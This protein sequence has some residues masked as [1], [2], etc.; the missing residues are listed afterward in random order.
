MISGQ[1][2]ISTNSSVDFN[3]AATMRAFPVEVVTFQQPS[4]CAVWVTVEDLT[5]RAEEVIGA[6][7]VKGH[8]IAV[9]FSAGK[10]SSV[11]LNLVL[12]VAKG[13]VSKGVALPPIVVAHSDTM[14][15][16]PE[17]TAY[18]AKEMASVR[19]FASK[20]RLNVAVEIARP[21][22]TNQWPVRVI[23]GR[24]LPTFASSANRDCTISLK[25]QPQKKLRKQLLKRLAADGSGALE[26]ITLLGTRFEESTSREGRMRER[27]ESGQEVRRG[28]DENGK[29]AGLFLSPIADW[30]SDDVWEYLGSAR[31][32]DIDSYS[33]F[34]ETFR[35]YTAGM[36]TSCVIV[37][38]D[39]HKAMKASRA[40]GARTGCHVCTAVAVDKSMEN[41]IASDERY[42]YMRGLNQFRNFLVNTR[43]DM[44]RR[45]WLGR[46]INNGYV[47][48]GADAYS[49]A[50]ME[51]LLKYALTIDAVEKSAARAAG[52]RPR[53]QMVNL[54]QLFAID[55]MWSLQAFHRPFHA[56]RIFRDIEDGARYPV[57]E[58]AEFEK[59]KDMPSRHLY[60]GADWDQG[61]DLAYTGLRSVVH[62]MV[63]ADSA[64]C[65]GMKELADGRSVLDI[66]TGEMME[67]DVESAS[68]F[69]YEW[70]DEV[71]KDCHDNPAALPTVAYDKYI[72][73]GALSVKQGMQG[74]IDSML[75]RS[76]FKIREGLA[77]Q[78][79]VSNLMERTISQKEFEQA[80]SE[81]GSS[82]VVAAAPNGKPEVIPVAVSNEIS[83]LQ[84]EPA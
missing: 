63:A 30:T 61:E 40:C 70:F 13:L 1:A 71:M 84:L 27:G 80:C 68:Y 51:E 62:E 79:D 43:W 33:D 78:V 57:P 59:P 24:G 45:A 9:A 69:L 47:R 50:M 81:T 66:N 75:R 29:S 7:L 14:V 46:T 38:E 41:M 35:I 42:H 73:L 64:G 67:I 32:G 72:G 82:S 15:E 44:G 6:L 37:A 12:S 8:P 39:M 18:A 19:R 56:L 48:I 54:E 60:V 25:I 28:V 77:G 5:T 21:L 16:S 36:S 74:E 4:A 55:A 58:V 34:E 10:D 22:L 20:H 2:A 17:M 26:C 11:V 76:N 3:L 31:S 83:Q 52:V 53:F 65:M 23:G 49:P